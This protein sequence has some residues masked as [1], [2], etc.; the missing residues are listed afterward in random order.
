[1][2]NIKKHL[3]FL[4]L[5][6]GLL[7]PSLQAATWG[8]QH[9]FAAF[10]TLKYPADFK[11]FDYVNPNAPKGGQITLGAL[12]TFDSLNPFIIKGSIPEG[13]MRCY[14]TLLAPAYDEV[15]SHYGYVATKIELEVGGRG[16]IFHLN[17][18]ACFND[19]QPITADDVIFS[20]EALRQH[21]KPLFQSYYKGVTKVERISFHQIKFTFEKNKNRELVGNLGRMPILCKKFYQTHSFHETTLISPP[22]SG[23]YA[24]ETL[25][26][27]K[28]ITY[29]RV[30][31]WWAKDLPSQRGKHNF[32]IIKVDFYRDQNVMLEAFKNGQI[33]ARIEIS[34]KN[35]AT[36]Y[37]FA[38]FKQ[39]RLKKQP[40]Y[41]HKVS[42][43]SYGLYFNTRRPLFADR[44]VRMALSQV[45]D[46]EWANNNLFYKQSQRNNS[47]FPNFPFAAKG[48]PTEQER[49]L[50]EPFKDQLPAELFIEPFEVP[51]HNTVDDLQKS[52]TKALSLLKKAG[53]VLKDQKLV[54]AKTGKPF[55]FEFLIHIP[56]IQKIVIHFQN[57]LKLIGVEMKITLVDSLTYQERYDN[58]DYDMI[59]HTI[60]Q[61]QAPGGEQRSMWSSA[62]ADQL[63]T[64]NVAGIKNPVIDVLIE[65]LIEAPDYDT[66]V[67]RAR[68]LDRVLL[69]NH[70]MIPAWQM[71]FIP[72]VVWDRFGFPEP[73]CPP[74]SPTSIEGWWVD[75]EKDRVLGDVVP[76]KR[77]ISSSA[78]SGWG[79]LKSWF[80]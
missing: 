15:D 68:A 57:C 10:G 26:E 21:G 35:W 45:F 9:S 6:L 40:L 29:R 59:L 28:S 66:M 70:Y 14:A 44:D 77:D 4:L 19:G 31:N 69:W 41:G 23:P 60:P 1:M 38:A 22:C 30:Q 33:D 2:L 39:G 17:P 63:R 55:T 18:K 61:T 27:G 7:I 78:P 5:W 54:H 73:M 47:Y 32:D 52:R 62:H 71:N 67:V 43:G 65:K 75:P 48:V 11:H 50:L 16:V 56:A 80:D 76:S 13:M 64:H 51:V 36:E 53:W 79:K 72:W 8:L 58:H 49:K 20:F 42:Y 34:T 24:V 37:T 3:F 46:F 25:K 12:G 74:Y